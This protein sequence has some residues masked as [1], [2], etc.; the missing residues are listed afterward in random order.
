MQ[1]G[2]S[3]RTLARLFDRRLGMT[4]GRWLLRRRIQEACALLERTAAI[5][6]SVASATGFPDTS[7]FRRRFADEMSTTPSAYRRTFSVPRRDTP[8]SRPSPE[9]AW[10]PATMR[11][12]IR[13]AKGSATEPDGELS[14][15]RRSRSP[16][17]GGA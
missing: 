8:R 13:T 7:N 3:P 1:A 17:I 14:T 11:P 9:M 5:I 16:A 6:E 10:R 15:E 2:V 12:A 4:P